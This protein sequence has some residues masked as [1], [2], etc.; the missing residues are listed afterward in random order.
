MAPDDFV[1]SIRFDHVRRGMLIKLQ[2]SLLN[3][4]SHFWFSKVAERMCMDPVLVFL[5]YHQVTKIN[6][7]SYVAFHNFSYIF[8]MSTI[9]GHPAV[10]IVSVKHEKFRDGPVVPNMAHLSTLIDSLM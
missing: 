3:T 10:K 7:S 4:L 2:T 9:Q 5:A 8:A 1:G 6:G